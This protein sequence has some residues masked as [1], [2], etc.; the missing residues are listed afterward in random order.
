MTELEQTN[1]VL[2]SVSFNTDGPKLTGGQTRILIFLKERLQNKKPVTRECILRLYIDC[3]FVVKDG[4][5]GMR[6]FYRN[7][8]DW[9]NKFPIELALQR[10]DI[11]S[12]GLQ[13][14]KNN[15]GACIIKGKLIAIP[16]I[17]I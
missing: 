12:G 10:Y 14:F 15:L 16:V 11:K 8:Y 4:T 7:K 1:S 17:E 2:P 6:G 13:W 5:I 3:K 9:H